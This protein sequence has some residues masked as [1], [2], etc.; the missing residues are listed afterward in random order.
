MRKTLWWSILS[1]DELKWPE[2]FSSQQ[3]PWS[4]RSWHASWH[5]VERIWKA[6]CQGSVVLTPG[7][8]CE[9]QGTEAHFFLIFA[10]GSLGWSSPCCLT[11]FL[12]FFTLAFLPQTPLQSEILLEL[13]G[14]G[15]QDLLGG[16]QFLIIKASEQKWRR[17][18]QYYS[19]L[20]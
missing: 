18:A 11:F 20:A 5:L 16:S 12:S 4:P 1:T 3:Y 14:N 6:L 19:I 15:G 7:P 17:K 10:P 13:W 9:M 8:V 2:S